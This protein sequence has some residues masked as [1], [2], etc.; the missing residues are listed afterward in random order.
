MPII[1]GIKYLEVSVESRIKD[2]FIACV[3]SLPVTLSGVA[4]GFSVVDDLDDFVLASIIGVVV[5]IIGVVVSII[6][7]VVS[8]NGVLV[9]DEG[10]VVPDKGVVVSIKGVVVSLVLVVSVTCL[11]A[12]KHTSY[13]M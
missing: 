10:V 11:I 5:S 1:D 8:I 13:T 4:V 2:L 6:G 12:K 7:V 3:V 9:P